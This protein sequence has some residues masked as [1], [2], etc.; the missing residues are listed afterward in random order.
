M[1]WSGPENIAHV[2]IDDESSWAFLDSG[3]TINAV[4]PECVEAC[5]L[6]MGPLS[7]LVDGILK[8]NVIILLTLRLCHHKGSSRRGEGL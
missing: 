6:D 3:Y 7:D 5:S 2:R 1:H 4:T 8:I